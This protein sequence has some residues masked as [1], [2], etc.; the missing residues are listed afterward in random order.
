LWADL[1]RFK[2]PSLR[3]VAARPPY[4]HNGIAKS[5][6]DVVIHYEIA[7]GFKFTEQERQ[8]LVAFM[9]AL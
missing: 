8:D 6:R 1:D 5:L 7:L 2:T 4:F 9:E 3:G